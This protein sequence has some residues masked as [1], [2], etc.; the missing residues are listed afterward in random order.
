M[1]GRC[2]MDACHRPPPP[3]LAGHAATDLPEGGFG[4]LL[5]H[6]ISTALTYRR[7]GG[8]NRLSLTLPAR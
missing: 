6:Q 2:H 4:W 5:I 3:T 7:D 1:A 8:E